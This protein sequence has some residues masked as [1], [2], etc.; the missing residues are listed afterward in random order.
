[1]IKMQASL[2][3]DVQREFELLQKKYPNTKFRILEIKNP[4]LNFAFTFRSSYVGITL[5][6]SNVYSGVCY[7]KIIQCTH[8]AKDIILIYLIVDEEE[9][10]LSTIRGANLIKQ[11]GI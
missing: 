2:D 4:N 3:E 11:Y 1:M 10:C 6:E 7:K 9:F 8:K 5:I